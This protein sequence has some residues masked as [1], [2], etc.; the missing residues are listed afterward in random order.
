[1][2]MEN[3]PG[4]VLMT[5]FV[6]ACSDGEPSLRATPSDDPADWAVDT[7]VSYVAELGEPR[8]A[9]PYARL[10]AEVRPKAANNNVDINL[11][12]DRLFIAWRTA[13]THYADA[14]VMMYVMSSDNGGQWWSF[15]T[16]VALQSDVREPRLLSIGGR[17][18][19]YFFE[20]GDNPIR[21]EPKA[22][23]RTEYLAAGRWT[24]PETVLAPGEVPWDVK[25]RGGVA[26]MTSYIGDTF[27]TSGES[28]IDIYMKRSEDGENW[29]PVDAGAPVSYSGGA[30]EAAFE[31]AADGRWW[32]V[33]RN[34]QGDQ[35]GFGS[36]LCW[37]SHGTPGRWNCPA[38]ADPERYDSPEM[39]RHGDDLYLLARRDIGGPY[40]A[41]REDLD[42]PSRRRRYQLDYWDRPKR[43]ALYRI[44]TELERVEFVA[45]L[46]SAGDTAF[47]SVRRTG[48][49][50]FLVANY[51]SPLDEP[52]ISWVEGQAGG[53]QIYL[54]T[55]RFVPE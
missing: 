2:R 9:I 52:D 54:L 48:A 51:T 41:G 20:A 24:E 46:P 21:F 10:P 19:L 47:P 42:F 43:T 27:Y 32:V 23:W 50:T 6:G 15:E 16:S 22:M 49:H 35:T 39:F 31:R 4:L 7:S 8:F 29:A 26:Y 40:D 36:H 1:M 37:A 3:Q 17:L 55:L 11:H 45:D 33:L 34:E 38:R 12:D 30:S 28:R 13:K 18:F 53:T 5:L 25:V 44:N 14:D